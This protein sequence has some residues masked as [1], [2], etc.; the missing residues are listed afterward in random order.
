MQYHRFVFPKAYP[1]S[2]ALSA[3]SAMF[4]QHLQSLGWHEVPDA[5]RPEI[6]AAWTVNLQ[7][8]SEL[9]IP[10]PSRT[11]RGEALACHRQQPEL[12]S[13][14]TL[15]LL[16]AFRRCTSS[17]ERLLVIDWQHS[18][19]Y[20][21]P[22]GEIKV[23]TLDEWAV[24][25]LPEWDANQFVAEDFRFGVIT[26]WR[27]TGPVTIFGKDLLDAFDTDPPVDFLRVCGPGLPDIDDSE[28]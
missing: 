18:W 9:V 26:G 8:D 1:D 27:V 4:R 6:E 5:D 24:P 3:Y 13:E 22:H 11:W 25:I 23:A 19:Y 16:S 2:T 15:K 12:E 14:F 17:E 7:P 28:W 10:K 20:L 21:Y